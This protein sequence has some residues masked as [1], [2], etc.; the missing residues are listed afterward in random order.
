MRRVLAWAWLGLAVLACSP[1]PLVPRTVSPYWKQPVE[2]RV[3]PGF[4]AAVLSLR[5]SYAQWDRAM[6]QLD[7]QVRRTGLTPSGPVFVRYLTDDAFVPEEAARW[8]VGVPIQPADQVQAPLELREFGPQLLASTRTRAP[9]E[10]SGRQWRGLAE[11]VAANGYQVSGASMLVLPR[12]ADA[13]QELELRDPVVKVSAF[14]QLLRALVCVT[15]LALSALFLFSRLRRRPAG[16]P[17]RDGLWAVLGASCVVLYL[18]PLL[19]DLLYLYGGIFPEDRTAWIPVLRSFEWVNSCLLVPLAAHV[20]FRLML[21]HLRARWAFRATLG[22]LYAAAL[23]PLAVVVGVAPDWLARAES[24]WLGPCRLATAALLMLAMIGTGRN[25]PAEAGNERATGR[26]RGER[27]AYLAL[28][29]VT[30]AAAAASGLLRDPWAK[31]LSEIVTWAIPIP[32][33]LT[34]S[35]FRERTAAFDVLAKRG[36]FVLALLLVLAVYFAFV[37]GRIW[38][39]VMGWKGSWVFPVSALPFVV[40]VPWLSSWLSARLDRLW[41]GRAF[42]PAQAQRLFLAG[43]GGATS[44]EE[45]LRNAEERLASIF[46]LSPALERR[47]QVHVALGPAGEEARQAAPDE[48]QTPV[49]SQGQRVGTMRIET[50][51]EARPFLSEDQALFASLGEALGLALEALRLRERKLSQERAAQELRV[52]TGRAELRALRAQI[53]PHFVFNALNAIAELI[54]TDPGKA[55]RTVERLAEVLRH[56]L[57]RSEAE[58]VRVDEELAMVRAYLEV[59]R[60]RF[61]KRL[62]I[63]VECADGA[64]AAILPTLMVQTLVENAVKHGISPRPG[65]GRVEVR[66][67]RAGGALRV[68]VRDTGPGF[69]A[70]GPAAVC[71]EGLGLKNV[72]GRL[73][74]YFGEAGS[75]RVERDEEA[76]MTVVSLSMPAVLEPVR[77]AP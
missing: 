46:P 1:A 64:A 75:L 37:P 72:Q 56:T 10:E 12:R 2:V 31:G 48:F 45:L 67:S 65:P 28:A 16:A 51:P 66:A 76:G 6:W 22:T 35:Y 24:G 15:G 19:D 63:L 8:E 32:F 54:A 49:V 39:P 47:R 25:R 57:R 58:W 59:E 11:W 50:P 73:A 77:A 38:R 9:V 40:L 42:S 21:P 61:G 68:E 60:I 41:L 36:A 3:E 17:A 74:G 43:V 70:A 69:P 34:I 18:T 62:E 4:R 23:L 27:G 29:V 52:L 7:W 33:L 20:L 53:N 55:E 13:K 44:E 71:G 26:G 5:G 14:L 30:L